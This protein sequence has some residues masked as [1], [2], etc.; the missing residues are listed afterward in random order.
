MTLEM[1]KTPQKRGLSTETHDRGGSFC[2][3]LP[4]G[5]WGACPAR[6]VSEI[7]HEITPSFKLNEAIVAIVFRD[8]FSEGQKRGLPHGNQA[9]TEFGSHR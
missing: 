2:W 5:L 8:R 1:G 9:V 7:M 3:V 4:A 6:F